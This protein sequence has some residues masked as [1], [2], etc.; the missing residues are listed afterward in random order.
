MCETRATD[1]HATQPTDLGVDADLTQPGL[2]LAHPATLV[3]GYF[4]VSRSRRSLDPSLTTT[5]RPRD[6][7][8][9]KLSRSAW[10]ISSP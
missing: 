8:A 10:G 4:V 6:A 2:R 7:S 1:K 5:L 9:A 3:A